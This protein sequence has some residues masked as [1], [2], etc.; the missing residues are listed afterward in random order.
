MQTRA[1]TFGFGLFVAGLGSAGLVLCGGCRKEPA[2]APPVAEPVAP[3][4]APA[5]PLPPPAPEPPKTIRVADVG[6]ETP[7]SVLY[8][9]RFDHYLVSNIGG[10]PLGK[11]GAAFISLVTPEGAVKE[12][13]WIAGGAEGITLNAPKGMGLV[14]DTLYVADIDVVRMFDRTTGQSKGQ[15]K[16]K[17]ATFLNDVAVHEGVVYVSD[18]GMKAG[19]KPSGSDAVW[20]I[21]GTTAK[22]VHKNKSLKGPN[23]L[24][25]HE[26]KLWVATFGAADLIPLVDGKPGTAV[27]LPSGQLD[28]L[29]V[30]RDGTFFVSSWAA[31]AVYRGKPGE[32]FEVAVSDVASPADIGYDGK[33]NRLLIPLFQKNAVELHALAPEA[34]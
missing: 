21:T 16:I 22:V 9:E 2:A 30:G 34:P 15:V 6:F 4:A 12:L 28:G 23:G 32:A 25:F 8:D 3:P 24:A 1:W 13:K 10:D 26:G 11:D 18:S 20:A 31:S 14:E 19:F 5:P 33:R 27:S 17:G 7:E 29:F